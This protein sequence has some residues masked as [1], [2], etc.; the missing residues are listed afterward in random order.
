MVPHLASY[1]VVPGQVGVQVGTQGGAG[2][3][4]GWA[5]VVGTRYSRAAQYQA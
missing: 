4:T 1:M 5:G 2:G 3:Y